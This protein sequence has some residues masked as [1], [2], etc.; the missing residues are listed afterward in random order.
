MCALHD[1]RDYTGQQGRGGLTADGYAYIHRLRSGNKYIVALRAPSC[2][3]PPSWLEKGHVGGGIRAQGSRRVTPHAR[4]ALAQIWIPNLKY[5]DLGFGSCLEEKCKVFGRNLDPNT[6]PES[7]TTM[8]DSYT[9]ACTRTCTCTCTCTRTCA[10][11]CD[12]WTRG[13]RL[14]RVSRKSY[15]AHVVAQHQGCL[16]QVT[17][18]RL[19]NI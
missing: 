9:R 6:L 13:V 1:T 2:K 5:L 14:V 17:R 10:C 8:A 16:N 7:H 3:A 15:F 12:M 11:T 18:I 19:R 4:L